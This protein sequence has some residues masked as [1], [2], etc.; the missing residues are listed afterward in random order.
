MRGFLLARIPDPGNAPLRAWDA[1]D[2]YLFEAFEALELPT[3]DSRVLVVG[4]SFGAL[5]VALA[6]WQPTVATNSMTSRAAIVANCEAN[7]LSLIHI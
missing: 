4:D 2:E 7:E 6:D 1:A 5:S 3:G